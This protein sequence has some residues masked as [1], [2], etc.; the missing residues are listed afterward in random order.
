MPAS[1]PPAGG[2]PLI[3]HVLYR[4]DYGGLENGVVNLLNNLPHGDFRHAIICLVDYTEF[5]SRIVRPDVTVHALHKPPGN[6][7][8]THVRMYRLLRE[9]KPSI[10]HSRNLAALECQP[11]AA[12]AGVP[13][14]IHS[15]HGRDAN[16]VDGTNWKYLA[17]R[18]AI[19]PFVHHYIALS[20]DLESYLRDRIGVA[21]ARLSQIYN[22][23]DTTR[24]RPADGVRELPGAPEGFVTDDCILIGTVGRM[25]AVKDPVNLADAFG[26]LAQMIPEARSRLRLV[27][28]GDG[29]ERPAVQACLAR[30]GL[31]AQAWLPG[32]RD[33]VPTLL[34][35]LDIFVLPSLSEGISNTI[36]EAMACGIPVV[37]TAVGGNPELVAEGETGALVPRADSAALARALL[38]YVRQPAVRRAQGRRALQVIQAQFGL[39]VMVSRYACIYHDLLRARGYDMPGTRAADFPADL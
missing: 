33:D 17:V 8:A 34:R 37:A 13:V 3:A 26:R 28:V 22:G 5:R 18:R 14:R 9:L 24:F 19:R 35:A 7:L 16:D 27:M 38:D 11:V 4:L 25:D 15:E 2:P 21:D 36:L 1:M 23:V 30:H 31:S 12:L 29:A 32:S 20:K 6:S 39:P 10:V